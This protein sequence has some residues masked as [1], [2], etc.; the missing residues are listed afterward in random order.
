MLALFVKVPTM[1]CLYE[2]SAVFPRIPNMRI[3]VRFRTSPHICS[4]TSLHIVRDRRS[5]TIARNA[6]R[7]RSG[8]TLL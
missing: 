8:N 7:S 5:F 6:Q 2:I 4:A 3:T 1:Q